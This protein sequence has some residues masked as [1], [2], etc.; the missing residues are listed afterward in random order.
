MKIKLEQSEKQLLYDIGISI[1]NREY[2]EDEIL[3]IADEV[4]LEESCNVEKNGKLANLYAK[5]ADKLQ[6]MVPEV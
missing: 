6:G 3:Q 2:D 5:L 4:Y 1:E